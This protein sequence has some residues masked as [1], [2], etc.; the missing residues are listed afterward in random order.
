MQSEENNN[1]K[2][3]RETPQSKSL[4]R[5]EKSGFCSIAFAIVALGFNSVIGF[6]V[7]VGL[8]GY[9]W[10]R[11]KYSRLVNNNKNK[12]SSSKWHNNPSYSSL[13]G[14]IWHNI[15]NHR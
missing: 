1:Q 3:I 6:I 2:I 15:R 9:F 4:S 10:K 5:A 12:L 14:N 13:S 8:A 11:T 7:F